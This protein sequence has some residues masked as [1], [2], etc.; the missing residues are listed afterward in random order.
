MIA[1]IRSEYRKFFSTRLWWILM[2]G[3]FVYT[4]AMAAGLA[5]LYNSMGSGGSDAPTGIDFSDYRLVIYGLA[6]SMAYV[7][8]AIVGA[9][10]WTN[11]YRHHTTTPTYLGEPRRLVL[12]VAKAVAGIPMGLV[13]GAVGTLGA[14]AGGVVGFIAT[15]YDA[16][17]TLVA[18][19]Q[20]LGLS[21]L[22]LTIWA[23]VGVGLGMLVTSQVGVIIILLVWT[24]LIEALLRVGLMYFKA[25]QQIPQY[26]P[27]A[28][29]EGIAGGHS[30]YNL[31]GAAFQVDSSLPTWQAALML[32][33]YGVV[34]G[35]VGYFVR[36][37]RDVQ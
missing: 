16:G 21:V 32:A 15:G 7:F 9:L 25:T 18:T 30:I 33:G 36:I 34:F 20:T 17:L 13:I 24:Q 8:P 11:E 28:L 12:S 27:G 14:L 29:S 1:A 23:V 37:R 26:L 35:I 2:L 19:W 4:A 3:M 31:V 10:G 22:A 6:P 5:A